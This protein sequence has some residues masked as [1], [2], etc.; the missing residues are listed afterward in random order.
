M[1]H[2]P[3]RTTWTLSSDQGEA[4]CSLEEHG[5]GETASLR[6]NAGLAATNLQLTRLAD[7]SG[8]VVELDALVARRRPSADVCDRAERCCR[9]ATPILDE[10]KSCD[11]EFQ[12][13]PDRLPDNCQ[14]TL[15]GFRRIFEETKR[16]LPEACR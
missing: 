3:P 16:P 15:D 8:A 5:A 14:R 11:L 2:A 6:C 1:S 9:A 4:T 13:G 12:F 7:D 10:G